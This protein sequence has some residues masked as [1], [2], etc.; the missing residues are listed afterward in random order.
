MLYIQRYSIL[1]LCLLPSLSAHAQW[2]YGAHVGGNT[3][4]FRFDQAIVSTI[5]PI[6]GSVLNVGGGFGAQIGGDLRYA[7]SPR[8]KVRTGA[9]LRWQSAHWSVRLSQMLI[10]EERPAWLTAS[11]PLSLQAWAGDHWYLEAGMETVYT[12]ISPNVPEDWS[13]LDY[14]LLFGAGLA[15]RPNWELRFEYF[16]GLTR[17]TRES[18]LT[19]P[20]IPTDR[21]INFQTHSVR[22]SFV[23]WFSAL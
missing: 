19:E 16:R 18:F 13:N 4:F 23:R 8:L 3:A 17:A 22:V 20:D 9:D 14:G 10:R 1:L 11:V 12:L 2:S 6:E 21:P 15:P 7:F 5:D